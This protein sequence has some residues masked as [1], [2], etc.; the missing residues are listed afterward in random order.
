MRNG[1]QLR[2]VPF[3]QNYVKVSESMK[4]VVNS[5]PFVYSPPKS[6]AS[7]IMMI[8]KETYDSDFSFQMGNVF[9]RNLDPAWTDKD[10]YEVFDMFGEIKS[11]KVSVN[12]LTSRS[13]GYGFV[14]FKD[15]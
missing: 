2:L 9:V 5:K 15:T 12:S 13:N 14:W 11:A 4:K 1:K 8:T 3:D 7:P 6:K 10:L